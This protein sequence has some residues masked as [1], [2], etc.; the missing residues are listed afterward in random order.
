M[1]IFTRQHYEEVADLFSNRYKMLEGSAYDNPDGLEATNQVVLDFMQLFK[2][3]NP[4]FDKEKF[5][6]RIAK[7]A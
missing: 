1:S 4:K 6:K 2:S 5:V 7:G 3:D